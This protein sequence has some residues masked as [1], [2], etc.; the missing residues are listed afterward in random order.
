M[1][2]V[3][4]VTLGVNEKNQCEIMGREVPRISILAKSYMTTKMEITDSMFDA[5]KIKEF[6]GDDNFHVAQNTLDVF[7]GSYLAVGQEFKVEIGY[8]SHKM[9]EI[10]I[11]HNCASA[12]YLLNKYKIPLL[13]KIVNSKSGK[14]VRF[15]INRECEVV[16]TG[17]EWEMTEY[18]FN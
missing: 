17:E 14:T 6:M 13:F 1:R 2:R 12:L 7:E 16:Y 18:D 3:L 10:T 9:P 8:H 11:T 5:M 15:R 4:E